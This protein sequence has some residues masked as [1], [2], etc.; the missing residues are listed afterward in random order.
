MGRE[1]IRYVGE[2]EEYLKSK[3]MHPAWRGVGCMI[4]VILGI[5][6]YYLSGIILQA[7]IENQWVYIPAELYAPAFAPWL[8]P[9]TFIRIVVGLISVM[10]GYTVISLVYA[11]LFPLRLKETDMPPM[12]KSQRRKM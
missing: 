2:E 11:I 5:L 7:N 9:G 4:I 10:L 6:G 12:R 8:P 1:T 3:R